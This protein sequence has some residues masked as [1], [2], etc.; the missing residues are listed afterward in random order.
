MIAKNFS[1]IYDLIYN[2]KGH[3]YICGD[4]RMASDVTSVI[5]RGL[6]KRCNISLEEAK[7]YVVDMMVID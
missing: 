3:I 1:Q 4:V 2:K 6:Q 5:E 7:S